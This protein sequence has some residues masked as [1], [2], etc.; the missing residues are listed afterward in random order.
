MP[1]CCIRRI[2]MARD[3]SDTMARYRPVRARCRLSNGEA[4]DPVTGAAVAE[5]V[6]RLILATGHLSP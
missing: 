1:T 3:G 5:E 2:L 6:R 4:R